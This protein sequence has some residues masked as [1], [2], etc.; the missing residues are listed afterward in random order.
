MHISLDYAVVIGVE[1]N[2]PLRYTPIITQLKSLYK[3]KGSVLIKYPL[4]SMGICPLNWIYIGYV[5][6]GEGR[7]MTQYLKQERFNQSE[8][9][10]IQDER[11]S[12]S[13][14]PAFM[15]GDKMYL[16]L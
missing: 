1:P 4:K 8:E 13:N 7:E 5:P 10:G 9:K 6:N 2:A 12:L 16:F 3:C 14:I 11:A 15:H